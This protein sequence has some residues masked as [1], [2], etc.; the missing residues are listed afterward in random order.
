MVLRRVRSAALLAA[1]SG[2]TPIGQ[3]GVHLTALLRDGPRRAYCLG[4]ALAC[5][6]TLQG[7]TRPPAPTVPTLAMHDPRPS[8]RAPVLVV[9]ADDV[10][11][12]DA[13]RGSSSA[14]VDR[15]TATRCARAD[16]RGDHAGLVSKVPPLGGDVAPVVREHAAVVRYDADDGRE[17]AADGKVLADDRGELAFRR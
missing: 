3:K 13:D 11:E 4:S 5:A 17:L 12:L 1:F 9:L 14:V 10:R 8:P 16:G 7:T 6:P 15:F 2:R